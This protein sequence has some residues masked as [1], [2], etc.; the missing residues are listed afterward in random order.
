[1]QRE[2]KMET[3]DECKYPDAKPVSDI[4]HHDDEG[5][6]LLLSLV[7]RRCRWLDYF[8]VEGEE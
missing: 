2:K 1:M 5:I 7:V 6:Y 8:C 4:G 3:N